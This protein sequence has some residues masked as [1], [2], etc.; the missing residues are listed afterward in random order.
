MTELRQ[1][2]E[3]WTPHG[4][5]VGSHVHNCWE[6]YYQSQGHST[7]QWKDKTFTVDT[8]QGYFV[9]PKTPHKLLRF[10]KGTQRF[11]FAE[12]DLP[13]W[14]TD[15]SPL[16]E[17]SGFHVISNAQSLEPYFR[18][19]L[20]EGNRQ[21]GLRQS[22]ILRHLLA[23]MT[24]QTERFL[25]DPQS[26]FLQKKLSEPPRGVGQ[27]QVLLEDHP[28]H[29][30]K[31]DE[32]GRLVGM[33]PNYLSTVFART[34]GMPPMR[35]LLLCRIKRAKDLLKES[36]LSITTIAH[37]LGFSSIQHFSMRFKEV[38][39]ESPSVFRKTIV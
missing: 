27:A 16:K 1:F 21:P 6:I 23:M 18:L 24:L 32:L 38:T 30:W 15:D 9:S 14:C 22:H 7:W 36:E 4:W 19:L 12:W 20:T 35:Y 10:S 33:A 2:G 31:L 25:E 34:F 8:G 13:K 29:D 5:S 17:L 3:F 26:G 39:G 37:E 11:F 28:G